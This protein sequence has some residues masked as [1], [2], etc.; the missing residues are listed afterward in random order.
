M[1]TDIEIYLDKFCK[2]LEHENLRC[3]KIR[4][5]TLKIFFLS[6]HLTIDEI[7]LKLDS[8][9]NVKASKQSLYSTLK[10]LLSYKIITKQEEKDI[11]YYELTR[12]SE[13]FHL[14]C[15]KCKKH[16]D[17]KD[18][19][20]TKL[21]DTLAK[22]NNFSISRHTILLRGLCSECQTQ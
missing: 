7:L 2:I 16:F 1:S 6:M 8:D 4:Q 19:L 21:T 18:K 9:F 14:V 11:I 17:F 22:N 10:L 15:Q 5:A 20:L 12:S 3:T 13:H